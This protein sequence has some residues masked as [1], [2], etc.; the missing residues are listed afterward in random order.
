MAK[1]MVQQL[2]LTQN[3]VIVYI[4]MGW[5]TISKCQQ[6]LFLKQVQSRLVFGLMVGTLYPRIIL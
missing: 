5:M 6:Q 2:S 1:L 4:L 3:L